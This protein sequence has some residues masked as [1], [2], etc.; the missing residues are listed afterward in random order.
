MF[1][2]GQH[3]YLPSRGAMRIDEVHVSPTDSDFATIHG[4]CSNG[5]PYNAVT[6]NP[7]RHALFNWTP[8]N[9]PKVDEVW[10][11]RQNPHV[12]YHVMGENRLKCISNGV[13]GR[14]KGSML[15]FHSRL[16]YLGVMPKIGDTWCWGIGYSSLQVLKIE[17]G[18][19]H[20]QFYE[21]D[22]QRLLERATFVRRA[23]DGGLS[24]LNDEEIL[25]VLRTNP[26]TFIPC[27]GDKE[28]LNVSTKDRRYNMVFRGDLTKLS[29]EQIKV[30]VSLA[31]NCEAKLEHVAPPLRNY[32]LETYL[33]AYVS[34]EKNIA[35][36]L[37]NETIWRSRKGRYVTLSDTTPKVVHLRDTLTSKYIGFRNHDDFLR[38][39]TQV[40]VKGE[41]WAYKKA[42]GVITGVQLGVVG[43]YDKWLGEEEKFKIKDFLST[44][45]PVG[46][47]ALVLQQFGSTRPQV[48]PVIVDYAETARGHHVGAHTVS[49]ERNDVQEMEGVAVGSKWKGL[50]GPKTEGEVTRITHRGTVYL[51]TS[52]GGTMSRRIDQLRLNYEQVTEGPSVKKL[53][54]DGYLPPKLKA[55]PSV[56]SLWRRKENGKIGKVLEPR[57][58]DFLTIKEIDTGTFFTF[59]RSKIEEWL[60]PV[61]DNLT[62][63]IVRYAKLFAENQSMSVAGAS[64]VPIVLEGEALRLFARV[65]AEEIRCQSST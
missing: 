47:G 64:A 50:R 25:N 8:L 44:A 22:I 31:K 42:R 41:R 56:G 65:L 45:K 49:P 12:L 32:Q 18:I 24:P 57:N 54:E 55:T 61:T 10:A 6:T 48:P 17:G 33:A 60:D 7:R 13:V 51:K 38:T 20:F 53:V 23:T 19:V 36:K 21:I 9:D 5:S 43:F 26:A 40:L 46:D 52:T 30:A 27:T 28:L 37:K 62:A 4:T 58:P 11:D 15:E 2:V 59:H 16:K 34:H 39:Y 1:K 29:P 35:D 3:W 63:S 14:I